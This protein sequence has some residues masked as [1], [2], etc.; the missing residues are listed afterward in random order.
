MIKL[1]DVHLSGN[2][3][4][5]LQHMCLALLST[6]D[7]VVQF[8]CP[9][10]N[11]LLHSFSIFTSLW[12]EVSENPKF[13]SLNYQ[14]RQDLVISIL[15]QEYLVLHFF[16]IVKLKKYMYYFLYLVHFNYYILTN[17]RGYLQDCLWFHK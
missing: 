1:L 5:L 16:H 4:A 12:H 7:K 14:P 10:C 2:K 11:S 3:I 15:L 13:F 9:S 6:C 8:Y 17:F